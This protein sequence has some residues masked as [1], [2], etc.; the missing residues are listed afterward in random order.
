MHA[1]CAQL[2]Y[3]SQ[4]EHRKQWSLNGNEYKSTC[5]LKDLLKQQHL[6]GVLLVYRIMRL[7][8]LH[9]LVLCT[10]LENLAADQILMRCRGQSKSKRPEMQAY[11]AP[12]SGLWSAL[13]SKLRDLCFSNEPFPP[14]FFVQPAHTAADALS[15]AGTRK[16]LQ[17]CK[18]CRGWCGRTHPSLHIVFKES[19]RDCW[20]IYE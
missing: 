4:R 15:S 11:P 13:A 20:C 6:S 1:L 8:T 19:S 17:G 10:S 14:Y 2:V 16:A 18:W 5:F 3:E 12:L 7:E 9:L